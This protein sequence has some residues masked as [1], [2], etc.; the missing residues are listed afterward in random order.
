MIQKDTQT[1]VGALFL[2]VLRHQLSLG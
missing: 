1:A 2:T